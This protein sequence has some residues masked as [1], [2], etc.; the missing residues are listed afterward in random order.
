ME[1][2]IEIKPIFKSNDPEKLIVFQAD[3]SKDE[4]RFWFNNEQ[5]VSARD[6]Y[7]GT[8]SIL[9]EEEKVECNNKNEKE[10]GII[11]ENIKKYLSF[12]FSDKVDSLFI[13][14]YFFVI[15]KNVL[16]CLLL[17]NSILFLIDIAAVVI[18]EYKKAP[19]PLKSKH[20]A[21]H[22]IVNFLEEKK[23]LPKNMSEI[24]S[25]SR[26]TDNCGSREK[27]I[28]YTENFVQRA[29]TSV[30]AINIGNCIIQNCKN[31]ILSCIIL[32]AVY[33]IIGFIIG[34]LMKKYNKLDFIIKPIQKVLN[35]IVQ[36][37]NTTRKI[38]DNDIV[39]AYCAAKEWMKIVYPEFYNEE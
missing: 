17:A 27:T 1:E 26:F 11:K 9:Y 12:I 15:I 2:R 36:C 8:F 22:M 20:S 10:L 18:I 39:L 5:Y 34:I 37:F 38:E 23:R 33:I 25:A 19:I 3:S 14:I 28:G 7:N 4:I 6:N 31:R 21:E 35:N 13:F 16:I 24:K 32:I 30:I 29:F